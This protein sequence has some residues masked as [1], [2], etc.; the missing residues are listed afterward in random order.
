[1]L[2]GLLVASVGSWAA[3]AA[4]AVTFVVATG[5]VLFAPRA[6]DVTAEQ[7]ATPRQIARE[8]GEGL[9]HARRSIEMRLVALRS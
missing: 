4:N 5:T 8:I 2:G 3:F 9:G 1:M 7:A 6:V